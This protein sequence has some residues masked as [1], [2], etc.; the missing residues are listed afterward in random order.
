M[1]LTNIKIKNAKPKNKP[2]KLWD[3]D[4][5]FLLIMPPG[6]LSPKGAKYW[7]FKYRFEGK[8]KLLA[9]GTYPAISLAEARE[10]AASARKRIK[11]DIDPSASKRA[12]K[13]AITEAETFEKVAR[14]WFE[15]FESS[16][17]KEHADT[18]ESRLEKGL[19]RG[20]GSKPIS[21]LKAMDLLKVLRHIE[22]NGIGKKTA[23]GPYL[24]TAHRVKTI[25]GQVF[26]YGVATGRCERDIS[27][28]L[29]GAIQP[30]KKK[31]MAAIT[32][33]KKAGELLRAIDNYWG[34]RVTQSALKLAPLVFVRPGELRHAKWDE[35]DLEKA[36]WNIP[37]EKMKMKE[38]HLVPLCKQAVE[39]LK[40]LKTIT[41]ENDYVFP[42]GRSSPKAQRPMSENAIL[43][44]LRGMGYSKDEMTG[45]GFRAMARTMLDEIL[46]FP[47]EI[48]E[49]QL[50]HAVRDPLGRAYNR[51]AHLEQRKEMMQTWA[52]YLDGLKAGAKV[53]PFKNARK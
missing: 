8:E 9:L 18:I 47:V 39:I 25:A 15:R 52:D 16:W 1:N 13:R 35:I 30:A 50:A 43:A 42:S 33:P 45:H 27:A 19:F 21:E 10:K 38:P 29:K 44:A 17:T 2:Y 40:E 23:P 7:R 26:R 3:R 41:G 31:H 28:D 48:I 5:L 53:I 46:N 51:T 36:E 12:A 37:P 6:R 22:S 14:E 34:S 20:L 49:H 4:G 24:E 11:A 32:E